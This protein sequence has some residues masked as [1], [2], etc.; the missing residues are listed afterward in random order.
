MKRVYL[1]LGSNL[2]DRAENLRA[3]IGK[4][5][6]D[7]LRVTRESSVYETK[8]MYRVSQPSFLNMVVEAET[9]LLPRALL[10]RLH[11][12]EAELGRKRIAVNGPRPI[13]LDIL[14]YGKALIEMPQLTVPHP[15]MQERRFVIEP[16]AEIAPQWQHPL[17]KKS[18]AQMLADLPE[19]GVRKL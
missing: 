6:S 3:A 7:R 11:R 18:M 2:G 14:F 12:I 4:M 9:E 19:Q 16:M 17:I 10:Q 13:D 8:P 5:N 15:R 1:A